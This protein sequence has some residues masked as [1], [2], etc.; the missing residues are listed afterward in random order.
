MNNMAMVDEAQIQI[1]D[2][3]RYLKSMPECVRFFECRMNVCDMVIGWVLA[4]QGL[5]WECEGLTA[6]KKDI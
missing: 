2:T 6:H 1:L 4:S 3:E 5:I